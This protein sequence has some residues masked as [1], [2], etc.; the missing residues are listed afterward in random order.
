MKYP[1]GLS[2]TLSAPEEIVISSVPRMNSSAMK[3]LCWYALSYSVANCSAEVAPRD[4]GYEGYARGCSPSSVGVGSGG[5]AA[6]HLPCSGVSKAGVAVFDWP[7]E[8][9]RLSVQPATPAITTGPESRRM[10][11]LVTETILRHFFLTVNTFTLS[12]P[13]LIQSYIIFLQFISVSIQI[14]RRK[15]LKAI[16][17]GALYTIAV[18][19]AE[20]NGSTNQASPDIGVINN[21]TEKFQVKSEFI[22]K[23][24]E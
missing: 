3:R 21:S 7:F 18:T 17:G 1:L 16:S 5:D 10:T 15:A 19:P 11:R 4:W 8:P 24:A 9:V 23:T 13:F 14:N 6:S 12:V 22:L 20:A 2:I